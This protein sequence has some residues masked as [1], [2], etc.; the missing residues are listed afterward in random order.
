MAKR[1]VC[2]SSYINCLHDSCIEMTSKETSN[3]EVACPLCTSKD[4]KFTRIVD[5]LKHQRLF[6]AHQPNFRL[7]CDIGGCKISYTNMGTFQNHVYSLTQFQKTWTS[8]TR[9]PQLVICLTTV[10]HTVILIMMILLLIMNLQE[11]HCVV[12]VAHCRIHQLY[13]FLGWKKSLSSHRLQ[14]KVL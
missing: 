5:Y 6:H 9:M 11:I 4:M 12:L 8:V 10:M 7:T 2:S 13:S 14:C 3:T 1:Y